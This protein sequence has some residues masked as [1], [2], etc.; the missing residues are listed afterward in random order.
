MLYQKIL[1]PIL[2]K[3]DPEKVHDFF[4][5][6]GEFLGQNWLFRKI[7]SLF[8][9]YQGVDIS[10]KINGLSFRTPFI[11]S[12]G[13][14]YN[15]RLLNIL[16][17]IS[18]GGMEV[19][20]ITARACAGNTKPR[21]KRLVK[22]KSILVNKGLCNEGVENIINRLKKFNSFL[23]NKERKFV[24]GISIARTNDQKASSSTEGIEDYFYSF[25]RLNEENLGDYYVINI[26]CPN[27]FGGE[28]FTDPELLNLLISKI[29]T[30]K[31][32]KPVYIKM[33]IN[34]EWTEFDKLLKI[35]DKF[36]FIKGLVIGN[37]NK[38]YNY[39]NNEDKIP[40]KY[41]G[42]LSGKPCFEIS[43]ELIRQTKKTYGSRFTIIGCGG[44][45]SSKD[46]IEKFE[47]G[48]DLVALVTGMIY[49]GPGFVKELS[50]AYAKYFKK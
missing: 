32:H 4:V 29:V 19:G 25:R 34:L 30:I 47:A 50:K 40:E 43:N 10:K 46:M 44:V 15:G 1:K 5:N 7:I 23:F 6:T 49:N 33:P 21:L 31:C 26:S 27:A 12:A 3:F 48:S 38:N 8:Y 35:L 14:D 37:L 39:L 2:F 41:E 11:L 28:T 22:S 13:F 24:V 20:S 45:M 9:Q 18:F 16:P 36:E 17:E 42:G